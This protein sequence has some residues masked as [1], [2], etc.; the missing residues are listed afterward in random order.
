M[1]EKNRRDED[2]NDRLD[3]EMIDDVVDDDADD[4]ADEPVGRGGTATR[5]RT[6]ADEADSRPKTKTEGRV[7][8]FGRLARFFREVVAELRKVIWPTRKELLTYT[9]VVVVFVAVVLTIV[10]GLDYAFA[11]GV[12]WV[13]GGSS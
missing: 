4:E 6:K 11:R 10:A 5:E 13:F 1:A 3:D 7:G 2:D 8:I 12:L 9:A